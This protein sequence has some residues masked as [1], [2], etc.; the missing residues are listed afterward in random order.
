MLPLNHTHRRF[1]V[2]RGISIQQNQATSAP[3]PTAIRGVRRGG[4]L[5]LGDRDWTTANFR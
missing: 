5:R 2:V 3:L 1:A 4:A